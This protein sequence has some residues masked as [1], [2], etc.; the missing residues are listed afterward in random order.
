MRA[1]DVVI[2]VRRAEDARGVIRFVHYCGVT[3]DGR[4]F[5][6]LGCEHG[7]PREAVEHVDRRTAR[8]PLAEI[9][10]LSW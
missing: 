9:E 1:G 2:R 4:D 10:E 3:S 5:E 7:T 6:P 8:S